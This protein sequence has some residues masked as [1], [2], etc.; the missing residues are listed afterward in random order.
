[1][2]TTFP[3]GKTLGDNLLLSQLG[4]HRKWGK[5]NRKWKWTGTYQAH[6]C[7][8]VFCDVEYVNR[9]EALELMVC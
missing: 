7:E 2:V 4:S 8:C 3:A 6:I 5:A 9:F 1:M